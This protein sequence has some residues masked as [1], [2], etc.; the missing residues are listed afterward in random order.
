MLKSTL[1]TSSVIDSLGHESLL[2]PVVPTAQTPRAVHLRLLRTKIRKHHRQEGAIEGAKTSKEKIR[3]VS[4]VKKDTTVGYSSNLI[5]T[6]EDFPATT[7]SV[8]VSMIP[9]GDLMFDLMTGRVTLDSAGPNG[10][11]M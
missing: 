10:V 8:D 7:P 5:M 9:T 4:L 11:D 2:L 1:Q 3:R 6:F